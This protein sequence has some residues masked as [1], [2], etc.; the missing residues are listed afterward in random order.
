MW[1]ADSLQSLFWDICFMLQ[2]GELD[3]PYL[4]PT[5]PRTQGYGLW[6]GKGN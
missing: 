4:P 5:L 6:Q 3:F 2:I 1:Q